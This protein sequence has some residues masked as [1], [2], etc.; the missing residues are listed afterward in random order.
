MKDKKP[1]CPNCNS[2]QVYTRIK[3]NVKVCKTC[4][5][6]WKKRREKKNEHI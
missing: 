4:G 3:N 5:F 6:T 1:I 2:G